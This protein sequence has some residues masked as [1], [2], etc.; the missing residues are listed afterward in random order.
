MRPRL[1]TT[2]IL[3]LLVLLPSRAQNNPY[4][5]ADECYHLFVKAENLVGKPG[6]EETS[7]ALFEAAMR[8]KD[9]KAETLYYVAELKN[10]TRQPGSPE[11]DAA[12]DAACQKLKAVAEKYGYRQ[13]YYYA[14]QMA[15]TYYYNRRMINRS[16]E[17]AREMQADAIA[18][19]DE[20][21]VWNGDKY[22]ASLYIGQ[23]DY[24]SAKP[25]L[26][27]ALEIYN[28]SSDAVIRRLR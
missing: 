17:L 13:Y 25:H 1:A 24:M 9:T 15:Q 3:L 16:M 19:N 8:L 6:F 20:Y 23:N 2:L 10:Q 28:T 7:A 5:I 22:L 4:E 14:Y 12:V 26:I 27:N 11:N 21:G 18:H